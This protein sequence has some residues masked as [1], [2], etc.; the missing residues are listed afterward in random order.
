MQSGATIYGYTL[1]AH[2][3]N[4]T[5]PL[6]HC[7]SIVKFRYVFQAWRVF[8]VVPLSGLTQNHLHYEMP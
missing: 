5:P 4:L 3:G 6:C 8:C 7:G 1:Q 2:L